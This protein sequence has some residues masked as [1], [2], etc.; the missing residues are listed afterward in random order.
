MKLVIPIVYNFYFYQHLILHFCHFL[1]VHFVISLS[2]TKSITYHLLIKDHQCVWATLVNLELDVLISPFLNIVIFIRIN[3]NWFLKSKVSKVQ[4]WQV[5]GHASPRS[6]LDFN[7]LKKNLANIWRSPNNHF[8]H[9]PVAN[10]KAY[11]YSMM[12]GHTL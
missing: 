4:L 1:H 3:A 5:K 7:S 6:V 8:L 11:M 12:I 10:L 9:M 2:S